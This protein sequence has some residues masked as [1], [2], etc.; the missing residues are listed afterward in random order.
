MF[1]IGDKVV[2]STNGI[3]C[4]TDI[5]ELDLSGNHQP[6]SYFLLKPVAKSS[7]TLYIPVESADSRIRKVMDRSQALQIIERL[8]SIET[9]EVRSDK[10]REHQYKMTILSCDPTLLVDM[11]KH[12]CRRS[13]ERVAQGKKRTTV[14]EK[15]YRIAVRNLHSELACALGCAKSEVESITHAHFGHNA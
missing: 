5:V 14:D 3:C 15:Y 10:E 8:D 1:C 9:M 6:K 4:I 7:S 11:I 13:A 2:S 12:I